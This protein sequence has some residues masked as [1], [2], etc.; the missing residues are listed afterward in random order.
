M[1]ISILTYP[2]CSKTFRERILVSA[3]SSLSVLVFYVFIDKNLS[4]L[5]KV[6]RISDL[7]TVL[8]GLAVMPAEVGGGMVLLSAA[9]GILVFLIWRAGRAVRCEGQESIFRE[10]GKLFLLALNIVL[11]S[12]LFSVVLH[13]GSALVFT[14]LGKTSHWSS[15]ACGLCA[16]AF[17]DRESVH[18]NGRLVTF[19]WRNVQEIHATFKLAG[20]EPVMDLEERLY[21]GTVRAPRNVYVILLESFIDARRLAVTY[22]R[23]PLAKRMETLLRRQ[24][25]GQFSSHRSIIFGGNSAQTGFELLTGVPAFD[26]VASIAYD[27]LTGR[28][29]FSLPWRLRAHGYRTL[30]VFASQSRFFNEPA[31]MRSLGFDNPVFLGD[32]PDRFP[33]ADGDV[34]MFDGDLFRHAL[35][36]LDRL[37]T[38]DDGPYLVFLQGMY[39][40]A[41]F[42]RN[43][44]LRPDVVRVER[45]SAHAQ[46]VANIF[47]Y[48]TRAL[49][50]FIQEIQARDPRAL[51][52]V[53][54]DHLP[55]LEPFGLSLKDGDR[56]RNILLVFDGP[57]LLSIKERRTYQIPWI[58]WDLL[59]GE[60]HERR[61]TEEELLAFHYSVLKAGRSGL[62]A[63]HRQA[64]P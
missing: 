35:H 14:A 22:D 4:Y 48:R 41:P 20:F 58:I 40:H 62:P 6:P 18:R 1:F 31:A 29:T 34:W 28:R 53:A 21:P 63:R 12:A 39:G 2:A 25:N 44:R 46:D 3:F 56:Y 36:L 9:V 30:A 47:L 64:S 52:V 51:I 54:S 42:Y 17:S 26:A 10:R 13:M 50:R 60:T 55:P 57:R 59:S 19:L 23:S 15:S 32:M 61:F 7:Y 11:G 33:K 16:L 43:K 24:G 27:V 49:A 45:G 38:Q 8:D 37:R 5:N